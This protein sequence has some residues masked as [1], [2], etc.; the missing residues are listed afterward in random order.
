MRVTGRADGG[1]GE[2]QHIKVVLAVESV[3]SPVV[4][5]SL[6]HKHV[7]SRS[8]REREREQQVMST[9]D[10]PECQPPPLRSDCEPTK[11]RSNARPQSR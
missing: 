4:S 3:V 10:R 2:G 8:P 6:H 7:P 1:G 9:R 11:R 5:L